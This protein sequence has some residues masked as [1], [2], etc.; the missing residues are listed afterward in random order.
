MNE[1]IN[2]SAAF[3]KDIPGTAKQ[4]VSFEEDLAS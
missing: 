3:K 1:L 4:L 2:P